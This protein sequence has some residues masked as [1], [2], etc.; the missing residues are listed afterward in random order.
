M[1]KLNFD[2]IRPLFGGSLT[3]SQVD[4]LNSL[5]AAINDFGIQSPRFAAYILATPF[6]ETAKTMQPIKEIGQGKTYAYGAQDPQTHQIYYGRGYVQLTWKAN[7]QK[8]GSLLNVDLVNNPDLTL[9]PDVAAKIMLVGMTKGL[10][11]G[12]KLSDY[13]TPDNTDFV[14]ARR[15]INGTDCAQL[16]AGYA[17]Q[18]LAALS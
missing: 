4:G 13:I 14:S 2:K 15:I 10:F 9:Q 11:T 18:F 1:L 5:M 3:Q 12:K 6:H 8:F 16:I 17:N 7:Y